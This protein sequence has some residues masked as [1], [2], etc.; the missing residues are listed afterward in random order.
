MKIPKGAAIAVSLAFGPK[1][2]VPVGRLAIKP[3]GGVLLEYAPEFIASGLR[4]NPRLG[5]PNNELVHPREP[6]IFHG[7]HG[8]FADSLPDAWGEVLLRRL[9]A[10]NGIDFNT[11][12]GLDRLAIVGHRAVGA[13]T[14]DPQTDVVPVGA[15]DLD[16]LANESHEILAGNDSAMLAQLEQLGGSPG[17]ARPK[18]LVAM[19]ADGHLIAG[20]DSIPDTYEGW[21]VK[22]RG[23]ADAE[24]VGPLEAAYAD[25]ARAARVNVTASRLIHTDRGPGYFSTQRFDRG[26]DG[27]RVHAATLAGLLDVNWAIPNMDYNGVMGAV[28]FFTRNEAAVVEM[29][30]R[31]VFNVIAGNRDDHTKQHSFLMDASGQWTLAPAYD[32]TFSSGPGGHHY[33]MVAGEGRDIGPEHV[34]KVAETQNIDSRVVASIIEEVR[35]AV[36]RFAEFAAT[37]GVSTPTLRSVSPALTASVRA[38]GRG[39]PSVV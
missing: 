27:T 1:T 24:D 12:T 13:L 29:F 18:V 37:Y 4:I 30:R 25:M 8:I 20:S 15:I 9:A 3:N 31:M 16:A 6:R 36:D 19:D 39:G 14:Y 10:T 21:M 17:G 5:I 26:H 2:S 33:L 38:F 28:R 35:T 32:L 7:L 22:F 34:R 23:P 11:L